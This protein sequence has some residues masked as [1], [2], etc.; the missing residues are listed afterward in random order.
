MVRGEELI[1]LIKLIVTFLSEHTHNI[2]DAPIQEPTNTVTISQI[3]TELNNAQ[4][5]IL[6]QNI[7]IN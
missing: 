5:T 3:T 7:R 1:N 2:N 4:N 6:N